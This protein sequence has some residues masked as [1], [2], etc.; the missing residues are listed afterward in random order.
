MYSVLDTSGSTNF[1]QTVLMNFIELNKKLNSIE[2]VLEKVLKTLNQKSD[3]TQT[4]TEGPQKVLN[5]IKS[6]IESLNG[7]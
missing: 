5:M 7:Q 2:K 3:L 4:S 1:E 6:L